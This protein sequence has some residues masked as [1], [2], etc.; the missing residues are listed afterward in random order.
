M[1]DE[2]EKAMDRYLNKN[3]SKKEYNT[4]NKAH[5]FDHWLRPGL[6]LSLLVDINL[7][8][9]ISLTYNGTGSFQIN[10]KTK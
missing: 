1:C 6:P 5:Y 3:K 8:A 7:R 2:T 10:R 4:N 9:D